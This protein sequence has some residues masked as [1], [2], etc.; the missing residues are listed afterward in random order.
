MKFFTNYSLMVIRSY[1]K[2]TDIFHTKFRI[3]Y[4]LLS[5]MNV[6]SFV[7]FFFPIGIYFFYTKTGLLCLMNLS[8]KGFVPVIKFLLH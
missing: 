6:K 4:R 5:F 8:R 2:V 3:P 1:V 7:P